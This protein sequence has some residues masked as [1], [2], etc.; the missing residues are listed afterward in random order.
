MKDESELSRGELERLVTLS[1]AAA[2]LPFS[3]AAR[4]LTSLDQSRPVQLH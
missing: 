2:S 4:F 3:I 1:F